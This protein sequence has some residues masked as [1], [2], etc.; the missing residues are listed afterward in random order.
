MC[1]DP[2]GTQAPRHHSGPPLLGSVG[3]ISSSR[4]ILKK[5]PCG[6]VKPPK[7]I[8]GKQ[9]LPLKAFGGVAIQAPTSRDESRSLCAAE[10]GGGSLAFEATPSAGAPVPGCALGTSLPPSPLLPA[11]LGLSGSLRARGST[12]R[13]GVCQAFPH[14]TAPRSWAWLHP[15]LG[16]GPRQPRLSPSF[17]RPHEGRPLR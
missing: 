13:G 4:G 6:L 3:R 5:H 14:V 7:I 12:E 17:L 8:S 2:G 11:P 9:L 1:T 15:A 10:L 16:A